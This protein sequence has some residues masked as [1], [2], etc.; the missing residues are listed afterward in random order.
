MATQTGNRRVYQKDVEAK[1]PYMVYDADNH[2]Y[3]PADAEVRHLE[4]Q[5][6]ERVFPTGKT[7]RTQVDVVGDEHKAKT[8][9]E[10]PVG[11]HGGVDPLAI[12]EMKGDIPVPGAM[13]NRMN[14]LKGLDKDGQESLVETFRQME[15][16]FENRERRIELMD[17]QGVQAAVI[18]AGSRSYA[19]AFNNRDVSAGY[20]ASR[21]WNRYL[22]ADWG[23]VH[24][25]R[26]FTPAYIPLLD[27][28]MAVAE[29]DRCM[30]EGARLI[31]LDTGGSFGRSPADP[32]FDP[33]WSR[34][35]EAKLPIV[36]HLGG[37]FAHRGP[38]WGE[39]PNTPYKDFNAFQWLAFWSDFPIMETVAML[40]FHSFLTRFPNINVLIAEHGVPWLPYFLRKMDHA[41]LLGRQPKWGGR[42]PTRPSEL[43]KQRF[44]IAP[45]PEE[46]V[47]RAID[48]VGTECLVFGSDFPHSEGLP[49]PVQYVAQLKGQPAP[50]VK[51]IMR[52]NLVRFLGAS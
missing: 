31:G 13:L 36:V 25:D 47:Q 46:N 38:D 48:V 10:H 6:V 5:Y 37:A 49:D 29:L 20:A 40:V 16:A 12:P 41:H 22:Q 28:D 52:D 27:V 30:G 14:P 32:L 21:A 23:F 50:V 7:H 17:E 2:I 4:K 24:E 43:F 42:L 45:F 39:D 1:L 19:T 35:N 8:L 9:G 44:M 11:E 18:H 26:V 3:P 51:A 33:Y 34:V 15:P